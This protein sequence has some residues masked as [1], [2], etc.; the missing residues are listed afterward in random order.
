[1]RAYDAIATSKTVCGD[2]NGRRNERGERGREREKEQRLSEPMDDSFTYSPARDTRKNNM[3]FDG[4][5]M[6][7]GYIMYRQP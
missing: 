1:M 7:N 6:S 5:S 3:K 4:M 2:E